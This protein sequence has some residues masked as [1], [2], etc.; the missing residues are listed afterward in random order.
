MTEPIINILRLIFIGT[1]TTIVRIIGQLA[2]PTGEQTVLSPS[3]FA[4]NGTMPV[5]FTIYGIFAYS[6]I[7]ALFLLIRKRTGGNRIWQGLRYGFACCAVWIVYLWE[8]LPHVAPLDRIT[9]PVADGLALIVMGLLLGWLFGQTRL[10]VKKAQ[11]EAARPSRTY[12]NPL[13]YSRAAASVLR[14]RYLFVLPRKN[15]RDPVMVPAGRFCDCLRYGVA[16]P[17]CGR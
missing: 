4:Q 16:E 14:Y 9:Y 6:L 2:I 5:A 8:P 3:I 7:A 17:L 12:H 10:P 1:A 11:S 13:L 15:R